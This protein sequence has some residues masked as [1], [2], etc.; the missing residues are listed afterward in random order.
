MTTP[1]FNID[2]LQIAAPCPVGWE[3]MK[4]DDRKRFCDLC[5]LNVYNISEMTRGEVEKLA[6]DP[7][8]RVCA[9][10]YRRADGRVL[11]R[12]CPVGLRAY[13]KRAAA[14]ISA[15]FGT[16]LG[17]FSVGFG[18]STGDPAVALPKITIEKVVNLNDRSILTG[19][20]TDE[21]GAVIPG[22]TVTITDINK[23]TFVKWTDNEGR[24][25]FPD[26]PPGTYKLRIE[27]AGF[28]AFEMDDLFLTAGEK[29]IV[30]NI[31]KVENNITTVGMLE[32]LPTGTQLNY[33]LL[34]IDPGKNPVGEIKTAAP[35]RGKKP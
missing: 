35:A 4:G 32:V 24:Y 1:K 34:K 5:S 11:M 20:A 3:S 6:A 7:D 31:L 25:I 10:I 17:L 12:D 8:G 16:V 33:E 13:R 15:A 22:A 23:T 18:Q 26:V 9:R 14:Y 19:T 29:T 30:D 2:K 28:K 21:P 27:Y